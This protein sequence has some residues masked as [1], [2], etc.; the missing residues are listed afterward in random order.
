M[1]SKI[2][3]I[4][5]Q[6]SQVLNIRIELRD[7]FGCP[8]ADGDGWSDIEI[9]SRTTQ[10][11]GQDTDGDKVWKITLIDLFPKMPLSN[12][13]QMATPMVTIEF[14]SAGDKF[15]TDEPQSMDRC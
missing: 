2:T 3:K 7:T 13:I 11:N 4:N 9:R 10:Q 8:D 15:P 6:E 14:G 12:T 5:A 1:D